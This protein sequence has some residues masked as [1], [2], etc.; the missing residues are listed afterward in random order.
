MAFGQGAM[1]RGMYEGFVDSGREIERQGDRAMLRKRQGLQDELLEGQVADTRKARSQ[2]E[3]IENAPELRDRNFENAE[4]MAEVAT[5]L[6][7]HGLH[8]KAIEMRKKADTERESSYKRSLDRALQTLL[9]SRGQNTKALTEFSKKYWGVE[10]ELKRNEDGS[11]D[12][13]APDQDG[14]PQSR[15]FK[16]LDEFGMFILSVASP[17]KYGQHLAKQREEGTKHQNAVAL[18][19]VKGE[20][21]WKVE[22]VKGEQARL[23]D[24]EAPSGGKLPAAVRTIM[25]KAEQLKKL[26]PNMTDQQIADRLYDDK[27]AVG[28]RDRLRLYQQLKKAARP[29]ATE[30]EIR[31]TADAAERFATGDGSTPAPKPGRRPLEA[32]QG[33]GAGE[34]AKPTTQEEFDALPKGARFINPADGRVL[35]KS[36]GDDPLGLRPQQSR[37]EEA[38]RDPKQR[39]AGKVYQTPKGP[40]RWVGH[41]WVPAQTGPR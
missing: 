11:I 17:E 31:A 15:R 8:D 40:M 23:R 22:R 12:A 13:T 27:R 35:I 24:R 2:R 7:R 30:E 29:F 32:F 9:A 33:G 16:N 39:E 3:A 4:Y 36:G 38:P 5:L 28:P 25:F 26:N 1:M 41:G 34:P 18:E 14:V 21:R 6:Q 37:T 20:E 10:S 19:R